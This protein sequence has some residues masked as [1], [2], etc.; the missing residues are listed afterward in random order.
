MISPDVWKE[1]LGYQRLVK[2]TVARIIRRFPT[3]EQSEGDLCQEGMVC[4]ARLVERFDPSKGAKFISYAYSILQRRLNSLAF[5][6]LGSKRS[7]RGGTLEWHCPTFDGEAALEEFPERRDSVAQIEARLHLEALQT[8]L[9][10]VLVAESIG[11]RGERNAEW[12]MRHLAGETKRSLARSEGLTYGV[13]DR[14]VNRGLK[15]LRRLAMES[16]GA[17]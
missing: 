4:V 10:E 6:W 7:M 16:E 13:A 15:H 5:A 11:G 1:A 3:L 14:A 8:E 2:S 9:E 17:I 12:T